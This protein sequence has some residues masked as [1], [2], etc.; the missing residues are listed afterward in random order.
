M[1]RKKSYKGLY[2][3]AAYKEAVARICWLLELG[4][5]LPGDRFIA[6]TN[7]ILKC[8]NAAIRFAPND[9]EKSLMQKIK[10]NTLQAQKE[11]LV[12]AKERRNGKET[13]D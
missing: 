3:T 10:I 11:F 4:K 7:N 9:K 1:R 8:A 5:K 6:N 13:C 12:I 2:G